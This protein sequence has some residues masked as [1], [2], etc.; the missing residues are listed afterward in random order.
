MAKPRTV[1]RCESCGA[2]AARWAG[3]CPTCGE[4]NSLVE[5]VVVPAS[6]GRAGAAGLAALP[7]LPVA[8]VDPLPASVCPTGIAE[9]DRVLGGGLVP[10]SVTLL[11]GEPGIG[12]STLLMQAL[13][14]LARA[15]HRC[16][17]ASGE[18]STQQVRLRAGRVDAVVDGLWLTAESSLPAVLAAVDELRPAV[19]VVDSIQTAIDPEIGSAPGTVSQVQGC[20]TRL[21]QVAKAQ[22]LSVV[23]VGHVTKEGGIAG[24]RL[25]EH[26]VDTVLTFEGERHHAL[27]LLRAVKHRFG[28]TGELG[29]F[30]MAESGLVSIPD[31]SDLFLGDRQIGV[32]GSAVIAAMEGQRP[33]LVEVQALVNRTTLPQPRRSSVGLDARRLGV[34]LAVLQR[35]AELSFGARD[36][37]V[38]AVGGVRVVEPAADLGVALAVVSAV[39]DVP[40]PP[41][42][43]VMGEVGLAGEIR[44]VGRI[45]PRLA[46]A[47]RLGF[48]RAI[49]PRSAPDG[50]PG[51]EICR[52]GTLGEAVL[53]LAERHRRAA[54]VPL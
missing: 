46:E 14:A 42:V 27:R 36:V 12:K 21:V 30:E 49:V 11:G 1:H 4:W 44:Q 47:A 15:G 38:S 29:L 8:D 13:A 20:A 3:R 48:R 41:G 31:P 16:L 18:E 5:E 10:G 34:V 53:T 45:A 26:V 51:I 2:V 50:P 9:L 17:L 35:R 7:V 52:V 28:P 39:S 25:L 22:G 24:P 37:Y 19:L 33:L 54:L 43:V 6:A 23:L 32:A 40:L